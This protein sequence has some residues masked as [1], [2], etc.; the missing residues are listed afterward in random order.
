MGPFADLAG[1]LVRMLERGLSG[2][3]HVV[4]S[5]ALTKFDFGVQIARQFGFDE[6]LI[7]PIPIAESGL[8]AKRSPNLRLSVHKLSTDLGIEIPTVS[9]GIE[10]FYTQAQQGYPQKMR[11]YQQE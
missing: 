10:K 9:T 7:Q 11:S 5:Q 2:L 3:Y 6:S 1:I 8:T 4:G